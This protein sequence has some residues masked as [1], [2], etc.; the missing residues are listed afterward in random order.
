MKPAEAAGVPAMG[1]P[2]PN[3]MRT[4][5]ATGGLRPKLCG[6]VQ[7]PASFMIGRITVYD[8]QRPEG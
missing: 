5:R 3:H 2:I 7:A 1:G 6:N 4:D 8:C